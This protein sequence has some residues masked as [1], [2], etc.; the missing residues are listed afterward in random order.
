MINF[1]N[2]YLVVPCVNNEIVVC[3]IN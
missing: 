2:H 1:L 3:T